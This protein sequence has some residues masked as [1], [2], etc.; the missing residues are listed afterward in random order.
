MLFILR[1]LLSYILYKKRER[2]NKGRTRTKLILVIRPK[3]W[4]YHNFNYLNTETINQVK[5][6]DFKAKP[7]II[8]II[9]TILKV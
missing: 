2:E 3:I 1:S 5:A 9:S 7:N 6:A 4:L 8:I